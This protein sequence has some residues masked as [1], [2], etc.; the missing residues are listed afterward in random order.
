MKPFKQLANL[1]I[2]FIL[3]VSVG[4]TA[5]GTPSSG[6]ASESST[7]VPEIYEDDKAATPRPEDLPRLPALWQSNN[8]GIGE[9]L[10]GGEQDPFAQAA[11]ALATTLPNGRDTA[12]VQQHSFGQPD[13][14]QARILA[15][16]LGFTG[17]L[18]MQKIAPEFAPPESE[19]VSPVYNAFAGQRILSIGHT[20]LN[21][22]DRSV[23]IDYLNPLPFSEKAPLVEA[24]LTEWGLLDFPYEMRELPT[25]DLVIYRLI[26]GVAV[27]Q[28][29]FN[30][31]VN[32]AG[33]VGYFD[34]HPL[35]LIDTLGN[36]P[37]LSA[38]TAWQQLQTPA[39]RAAARYQ[40]SQLPLPADEDPVVDFV[41]PRSW[42]YVTEP[43]QE[44]H[45]YM[46]PAVFEATDGSGL[47]LMYGNLTL[48]GAEKDMAEIAAH[49]S[50][51]LHVWGNVGELD[52]AKTLEVA[53]WEKVDMVQYE[54]VEGTITYA[55]GQALLQT[56]DD[57]TFILAAAPADIPAGVEGYVSVAARRDVGA[58]YPV[59]D[60]VSITE[61]IEWPDVPLDT[62]VEEPAA[63]INDVTV[64]A[65]ELLYVPLYETVDV[66]GADM[67]MLFLP[68]WKFSGE[69]D[70]GHRAA[71]WVP[72]LA[73]EFFQ[74]P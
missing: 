36:Y 50:D 61:K 67:S 21:F 38:E 37:L 70:Q 66:P 12:V 63:A 33:E 29:E 9:P 10:P 49:L 55:D 74:A 46:T 27:E 23:V 72:A 14:A 52:G 71:F 22:E 68:V 5:T 28:N 13:E 24:Q 30:F 6:I 69:T 62:A 48:T 7:A 45:L 8:H 53:G 1:L 26:E 25:G 17:P 4:C 18:Y 32:Q 3:F 43:G 60:W 41:N 42:T 44:L 57:D 40:L 73:D 35:R 51:V 19:I 34:Y 56:I 54:T 58:A 20:G 16:Q 47:H 2:L 39:G 15:D 64:T 11:F 59:L 31:M 65:V